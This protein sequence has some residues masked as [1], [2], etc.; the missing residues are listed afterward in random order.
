MYSLLINPLPAK[1]ENM[2]SSG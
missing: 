1:V 2:A